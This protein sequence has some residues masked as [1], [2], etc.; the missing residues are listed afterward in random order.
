MSRRLPARLAALALALAAT[1]SAY[2]AP[3]T[4]VVPE[5]NGYY[6]IGQV[7][8]GP[9]EPANT[10]PKPSRGDQRAQATW[11]ESFFVSAQQ[12]TTPW[13]RIAPTERTEPEEGV[14]P[15]PQNP[16]GPCRGDQRKEFEGF[17]DVVSP[18]GEPTM[19][20]GSNSMV[21][22]RVTETSGVCG[23]GTDGPNISPQANWC[24]DGASED[25]DQVVD[26]VTFT[27]YWH[28]AYTVLSAS[29]GAAIRAAGGKARPARGGIALAG[30]TI[31][32]PRGGRVVVENGPARLTLLGGRY[33]LDL[34]PTCD[35]RFKA[36][37]F[38]R[39]APAPVAP[40]LRSGVAQATIDGIRS[41]RIETPEARVGPA[42]SAKPRG[43]PPV[44]PPDTGLRVERDAAKRLTRV[45]AKEGAV[46]VEGRAP[47]KRTLTLA[48]DRCAVVRAG[49]PPRP[50]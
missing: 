42:R 8:S 15:Q 37:G 6:D 1:P 5:E 48:E 39:K 35:F 7:F 41:F 22:Q 11:I 43:G 19:E 12:S 10:L 27:L 24:V 29:K 32:V 31:V 14:Y 34:T 25:Y 16:R 3:A 47:G 9:C 2:G 40:Q 33:P 30:E 18:F 49:G 36:P 28:C 20:L 26:I 23:A 4:I 45:C 17:V 46:L 38:V 21:T 44:D 13:G 50:V